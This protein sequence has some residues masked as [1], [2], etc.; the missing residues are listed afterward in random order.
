M[1]DWSRAFRNG[2]RASFKGVGFW[3][4]VDELQGGRR[5]AIHAIPGGAYLAEDMG[6]REG[7]YRPTAYVAS[8]GAIG[9][10]LSLEAVCNSEGPGLLS[11]PMDAVF[12][13]CDGFRRNRDKDKNGFIAYD[14]IFIAVPGVAIAAPSAG[15]AIQASFS[16]GLSGVSL[17]VGVSASFS[18][19]VGPLSIGASA[20]LSA[21]ISI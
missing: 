18:A 4:E 7:I 14:L 10:G 8:D 9:E 12:A 13:H 1:V 2:G 19:A 11:L 5:V 6:L 17:S 3:V 20:S 21:G 15:A 16:A